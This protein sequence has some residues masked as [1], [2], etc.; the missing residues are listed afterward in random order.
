MNSSGHTTCSK[1]ELLSLSTLSSDTSKRQLCLLCQASLR[2]GQNSHHAT[3]WQ[4]FF[5]VRQVL[6]S[7]GQSC[8]IYE[9]APYSLAA[10]VIRLTVLLYNA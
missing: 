5:A 2:L 4:P 7:L 1:M 6:E 3:K 8:H 9:W 10:C